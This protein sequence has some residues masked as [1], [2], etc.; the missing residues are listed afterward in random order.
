MT[1][2]VLETERLLLRA[3]R[4]A[5]FPDH[6]AMWAHPR[7]TR[8]FDGY[9][10]DEE[11]CWLRFQRSLG[12][13]HLFG[14]GPWSLEEKASGRYLGSVGFFHGKRAIEVPYRDA[15]EAGWVIVPDRHGEGLAREALGAA[16]VW[17]DDNIEAPQIWCMINPAN[18]ASKKIAEMFGFHRASDA[19]YKGKPVETYLRAR[20]T[21]P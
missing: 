13:W 18:A 15:P 10:Y 5:D 11:L 8:D 14:F 17:A 4:L 16:F 12:Q 21:F 7:T 3:P 6:A 19:Q 9:A 20:G 2:P 1:I